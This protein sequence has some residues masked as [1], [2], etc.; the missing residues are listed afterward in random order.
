MNK[1]LILILIF[2]LGITLV[3]FEIITPLYTEIAT[4]GVEIRNKQS[5][6]AKAKIIVEKIDALNT[7]YS[8]MTDEITQ[9]N[10][11]LPADK[12]LPEIIATIESLASANGV[13]L[14]SVSFQSQKTTG[15]NLNNIET[16][17]DYNSLGVQLN[18]NVGAYENLK[19]FIKAIE[20]N[21]RLLDI[22]TVSFGVSNDQIGGYKLN[23]NL[24]TYYK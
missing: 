16:F 23:I 5:D 7:K 9:I 3:I 21:L 20:N 14:Q 8:S 13:N 4:V 2:I 11:L 22:G 24:L 12:N 6:L 1:N 18:A 17:L 19:S 15:E 10:N